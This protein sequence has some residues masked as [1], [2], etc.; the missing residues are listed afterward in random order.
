[1]F[2]AFCKGNWSHVILQQQRRWKDFTI[3]MY[4][5]TD[6]W[7][8]GLHYIKSDKVDEDMDTHTSSFRPP[9]HHYLP[10]TV[11]MT[12]PTLPGIHVCPRR[13]L[14]CNAVQYRQTGRLYPIGSHDELFTALACSTALYLTV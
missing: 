9:G 8:W 13:A 4:F 7:F 14:Q 1:M 5:T 10:L 2:F 12:E 3:Y 6:T 11:G